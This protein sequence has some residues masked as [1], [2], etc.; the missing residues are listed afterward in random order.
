[1][2]S[3]A[4]YLSLKLADPTV[5]DLVATFGRASGQQACTVGGIGIGPELSKLALAGDQLLAET[6]QGVPPTIAPISVK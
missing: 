5:N 4:A 3:E 6:A 2:P 1:L